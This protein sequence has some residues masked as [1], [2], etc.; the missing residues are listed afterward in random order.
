MILESGQLLSTALQANGLSPHDA[1][2]KSTHANHPLAVW[3]RSSRV[4]Y[5]WLVRHM[6]ALCEEFKHR[7]NKR[8]SW[9][10][11]VVFYLGRF[12]MLPDSPGSDFVDCTGTEGIDDIHEA[13][14]SCLVRKWSEDKRAPKWTKRAAPT[15]AV[16]SIAS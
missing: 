13:Y 1:L 3:V 10:P 15:W 12:D 4:N 9:S 11:H 14:R 6:A 16:G 7:R 8:H 2:C 5:A